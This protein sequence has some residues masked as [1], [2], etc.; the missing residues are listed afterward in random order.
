[1]GESASRACRPDGR[2]KSDRGNGDRSAA[3]RGDDLEPAAR[4]RSRRNRSVQ[5][6]SARPRRKATQC[7]SES[8]RPLVAAAGAQTVCWRWGRNS[9]SAGLPSIGRRARQAGRI[10]LSLSWDDVE[11]EERYGATKVRHEETDLLCDLL[12]HAFSIVRIFVPNVALRISAA[13][14]AADGGQGRLEFRDDRG[15]QHELRCD[16]RAKARRRIPGCP[17][18]F[19]SGLGR[20]QRPPFGDNHGR[21]VARASSTLV[22]DDQHLA[23]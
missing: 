11:G 18:C 5:S 19:R 12:P 10:D 16:S 13:H 17:D 4:S 2:D 22:G 7:R 20:L 6:W 15:G 9:L 23:A 1:M 21:P 3:A 14:R 8:G